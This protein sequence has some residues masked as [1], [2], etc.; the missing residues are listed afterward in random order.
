MRDSTAIKTVVLLALIGGS[1]G[2]N[3]PSPRSLG[4]RV[5]AHVHVSQ[6]R[7]Q[8]WLSRSRLVRPSNE[9]DKLRQKPKKLGSSATTAEIG[10]SRSNP[11][12][13][14]I[15]LWRFTRPHTLIGSALA[16]PAIHAL[17]APSYSAMFSIPNLVSML[18]AMFP[19]LLMN[20]YI[21]G[22]NQITDVEIDKVNKP[23]LPI[24]AGDLSVR[25]ATA[26]VIVSLA[27]SLWMGVA[28]PTLGSQGLNLALWGSG[29][30]GTMYSLPPF[31]L[32]RFPLLAA[33]C[34]VAVRGTIIN[35]GFF[36]HAKVAAFGG[37]I[38]SVLHYLV[39]DRACKLSSL[40]FGIFGIVVSSSSVLHLL[41]KVALYTNS[42][43]TID[44]LDE[45]CARC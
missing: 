13:F 20:L 11:L 12:S 18:Y 3:V 39:N 1:V 27:L 22:L 8:Q 15:V 5:P 36:A 7:Q 16:I 33:F 4:A 38:G 44:C 28:N 26:V 24:A 30:L 35:A 10:A 41:Y 34:I 25:D 42:L 23:D 29:I 37:S 17:A 40:F 9:N 19:A 14:L 21:T 2:F 6:P 45:R 31:R 32:K 43:Y